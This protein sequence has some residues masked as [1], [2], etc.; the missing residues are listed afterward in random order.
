[1]NNND[2]CK[3]ELN[4]FELH[5]YEIIEK[6][7]IM[8][9]DVSEND[10]TWFKGQ[11][12]KTHG[13][14]VAK[15]GNKFVAFILPKIKKLTFKKVNDKD[16]DD[17]YN[18]ESIPGKL[19]LQGKDQTL[20]FSRINDDDGEEKRVTLLEFEL[21]KNRLDLFEDL[22][23]I[24]DDENK[25]QLLSA[26]STDD[27][28][29][30]EEE[31]GDEVESDTE[32]RP[33]TPSNLENLNKLKN[34]LNKPK[35]AQGI[36]DQVNSSGN[37]QTPTPNE[38][39]NRIPESNSPS[40]ITSV[41]N[42]QNNE[43]PHAP[44]QN[45]ETPHAPAQN[46]ENP[47]AQNQ[48]TNSQAQNQ[49]TNSQEQNNENPQAPARNNENP[50]APARNN[51]NPQAPASS[52]SQAQN[53]ENPQAQNKENS[54]APAS[55]N[56]QAQNKENPQASANS[57]VAT[58]QQG[59][60]ISGFKKSFN[61]ML[62]IKQTGGAGV[63]PEELENITNVSQNIS[64]EEILNNTN[65]DPV[66]NNTNVDPVPNNTNVVPVPNNTNVAQEP[67]VAQNQQ[68]VAPAQNNENPP[69]SAV[70]QNQQAVAP[71]VATEAPAAVAP[72]VAPAPAAV[73]S[74]NVAPVEELPIEKTF[75]N[76][77]LGEGNNLGEAPNTNQ[78]NNL[79]EGNNLGEAPNTNQNNNILSVNNIATPE[80]QAAEQAELAMAN[81]ELESAN[82]N[83]APPAPQ[84]TIEPTQFTM[85][86][87]QNPSIFES[88]KETVKNAV[89]GQQIAKQEKNQAEANIVAYETQ[90]KVYE[91][92]LSKEQ[93]KL[94]PQTSN[95]Q[96]ESI[97]QEI[98]EVKD[99]ITNFKEAICKPKVSDDELEQEIQTPPEDAQ[100]Q[101]LLQLGGSRSHK[102]IRKKN[103]S[104]LRKK[105]AYYK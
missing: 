15:K 25:S 38:A 40:E 45:N 24:D 16:I 60:L 58:E 57:Q 33:P 92:Q 28:E 89:M 14:F 56:S 18:S 94:A 78:N 62:G 3:I 44:A 10:L 30:D 39:V 68:A 8:N 5:D 101:S 104:K 48:S 79:G 99:M 105:R 76:N 88:L 91:D 65:V 6:L 29:S 67:A 64:N 19:V 83:Q 36:E 81:V 80:N 86:N 32:T 93:S 103:R 37:N 75:V 41:N 77:N 4:F 49:S 42:Q 23:E 71:A 90:K 84:T 34:S 47:Q 66:P 50:Q 27:E 52:N 43:T 21:C 102:N 26:V 63:T 11:N 31:S 96:M 2:N 17:Q 54:E 55:S 59:G 12:S 53:K 87:T 9:R 85:K 46:N 74:N 98:S 20:K 61:S 1:M 51:E 95:E 35:E 72:A 22:D 82:N 70:A 97:K 13:G 7:L 73:A 100:N 69:A